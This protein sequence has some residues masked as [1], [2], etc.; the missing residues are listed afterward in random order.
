MWGSG[1]AC[2]RPRSG[3]GAGRPLC[4]VLAAAAVPALGDRCAA[5]E[6]C[7]ACCAS[8]VGV[9]P[10]PPS[11]GPGRPRDPVRRRG[12]MAGRE[13]CHDRGAV[14][15]RAS[16]AM[17]PR[18]APLPIGGQRRLYPEGGSRLAAVLG[19]GRAR[20][21]GRRVSAPS[22]RAAPLLEVRTAPL[23]P[24]RFAPAS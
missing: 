24:R 6:A 4:G 14:R 2:A 18:P 11:P 10:A 1:A 15:G 8:R 17:T 19:V 12:G 16:P 21:A 7:K 3:H 20:A 22:G 5:A 23:R 13:A 9:P